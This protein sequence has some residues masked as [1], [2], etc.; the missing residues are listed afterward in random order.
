MSKL[1]GLLQLSIYGVMLLFGGIAVITTDVI[2]SI[3][4]ITDPFTSFFMV[5]I[6]IGVFFLLIPYL[7][8]SNA[9][10]DEN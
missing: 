4:G 6:S 10:S 2:G 9:T 3:A 8:W 5:L 1:N 7:I